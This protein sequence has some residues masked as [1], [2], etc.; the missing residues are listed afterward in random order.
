ML[1]AAANGSQQCTGRRRTYS[2]SGDS[3]ASLVGGVLA[4]ERCSPHSGAFSDIQHEEEEKSSY[5]LIQKL[6]ETFSRDLNIN[7]EEYEVN[8]I[9]RLGNKERASNKPRPV[10][11]SFINNWKKNEIIK[12]KRNL[13]TIYINEDYPKE[14]L[15]RRREL[16]AELVEERKKGNT[17]YLKYVELIVKENNTSQE[18]RKRETS[19]SLSNYTNQPK[20]QQTVNTTKSNRSN[21]F[22]IMRSRAGSLPS[23]PNTK[24][25]Q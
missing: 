19:A 8:K 1:A 4:Y 24:R 5:E 25:N 21:A 16:Q 2:I 12:N 9:H 11:C 3:T 17:A 10:L 6:K 20:K 18:K 22:D 7:I 23:T 15:E 13:K 14:V